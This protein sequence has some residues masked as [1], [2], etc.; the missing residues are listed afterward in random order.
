MNKSLIKESFTLLKSD[1]RDVLASRISKNCNYEFNK[2]N[3]NLN[4]KPSLSDKSYLERSPYFCSGC[5]H[6]TSTKIPEGS[7]AMAGIG[8]HFMS[9]WMNR[10][11]SLFTHMGA[12]GANWIGMSS[13]VK[14]KHIFQNIGDGTYNHSGLLAIRAAVAANVNITYKILYNDAVAMTGGQPLDGVPT[15]QRISHQLFF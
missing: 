14:E 10:S 11:T 8:C 4:V 2:T 6:N 9:L 12:E 13:F 3:L 5:P 1:I 15:P 7:K